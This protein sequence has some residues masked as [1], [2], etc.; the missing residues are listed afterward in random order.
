MRFAVALA[1]LA[2]AK[3]PL[4]LS[5]HSQAPF[6]DQS[7]DV[8]IEGVVQRFDYRN[9][10][11]VLYVEVANGEGGIDVWSLQFASLAILMRAGIR[12]DIV[13]AGDRIRAIGHPSWNPESFG[14]AGVAITTPDGREFVDPLR[15][16]NFTPAARQPE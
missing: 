4:A 3:H 15:D 13:A 1:A 14:M 5:H 6:F 7:R 12:P 2:V 10:H 8:E 9:P 16:G 11:A